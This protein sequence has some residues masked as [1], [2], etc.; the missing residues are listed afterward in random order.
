MPRGRSAKELREAASGPQRRP[1]RGTTAL[2]PGVSVRYADTPRWEGWEV[3]ATVMQDGRPRIRTWTL[4]AH[5][6]DD[7]LRA[8]C[9]YRSRWSGDDPDDLYERARKALAPATRRAIA[10]WRKKP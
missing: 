1:R 4:R 9:V 2:V 10:A 6:P 7:A 3:R 5:E 8:A